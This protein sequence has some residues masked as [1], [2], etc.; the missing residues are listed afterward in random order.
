[1]IPIESIR[2]ASAAVKYS[3]VN[4]ANDA[5]DFTAAAEKSTVQ[6][7]NKVV[8]TLAVLTYASKIFFPNPFFSPEASSLAASVLGIMGF[9]KYGSNCVYQFYV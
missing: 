9:Q 4:Q 2:A 6:R 3:V 7:G 8:A 1:M 5:G